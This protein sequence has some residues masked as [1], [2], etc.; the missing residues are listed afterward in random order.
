MDIS[1]LI[2]LDAGLVTNIVTLLLSVLVVPIFNLIPVFN[3]ADPKHQQAR[4]WLIR[5]VGYALQFGGLVAILNSQGRLDFGHTWYVLL[6]I[7]L[8][9]QVASQLIYTGVKSAVS[10][11]TPAPTST[12][13]ASAP[14]PDLATVTAAAQ[15]GAAQALGQLKPAAAS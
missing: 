15:A 2:T 9:Q 4:D 3:D 11:P 6:P 10:Q 5:T 14:S 13:P 7:A 12:P 1:Q 8:G